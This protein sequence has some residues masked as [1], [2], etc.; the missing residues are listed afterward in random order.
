MN[1]NWKDM[2][3]L[4]KIALIISCIAAFIAALALRDPNLFPINMTSPAI[5]V[6][7]VFEALAYWKQN[8]K[9]A[10]LLIA[11]AVIS[12]AFFGAELFLL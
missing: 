3:L 12:L 6:I 8:R 4:Q 11:G 9:L 10:Y 2:T 1:M 5:A 7:T